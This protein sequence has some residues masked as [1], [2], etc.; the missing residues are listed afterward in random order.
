MLQDRALLAAPRSTA[1]LRLLGAALLLVGY[2]GVG[3][4]R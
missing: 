4:S 2:V 3:F 1:G